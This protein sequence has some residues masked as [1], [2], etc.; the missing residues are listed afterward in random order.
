MINK[1]NYIHH[2]P[3]KRSYVYEAL[4]IGNTLVLKIMKKLMGLLRWRGFG[5]FSSPMRSHQGR[6]GNERKLL[7]TKRF[8]VST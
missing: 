2:N 7:K 6:S 8:E 1:I 5:N 4:L 3:V